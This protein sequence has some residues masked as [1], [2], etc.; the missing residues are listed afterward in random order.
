MASR[1]CPQAA[2]KTGRHKAQQEL[3][4]GLHRRWVWVARRL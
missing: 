2:A 1:L 4:D 3:A